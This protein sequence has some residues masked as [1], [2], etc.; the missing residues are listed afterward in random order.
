MAVSTLDAGPSVSLGNRLLD[1]LPAADRERLER[2]LQE[3][4]RPVGATLFEQGEETSG[5][6][7]PLS[8]VTP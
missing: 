5:V 6:I 4:P 3:V 7:F 1:A 2:S 8:G